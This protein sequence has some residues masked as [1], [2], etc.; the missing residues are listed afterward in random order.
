MRGNPALRVLFALLAVAL[1]ATISRADDP[2]HP[3]MTWVKRH[4][5]PDAKKPSPALGYETT[6]GYDPARDLLIRYGGHNQGGG[7]EQ[8]SE[9]WTYDLANDVWT[10][11]QPNDAPP[12]V[13]CDQ[14]NVYHDA[15]G[16]FVR[17]P[18]FSGSHGWQSFREIN[19]KD[20]SV[21]TYDLAANHWR[22]MRP[23]PEVHPGPL[24]GAA[25]DAHHEV[26]VLH[27]GEGASHGT[28]A[29]DL[30]SNTWHRLKPSGPAPEANLS[31]PGFTYD[32]VNRVFV[33]F[34]SQFAK[35][36]K[37]WLYD[38]R[39]N[40][41]SVLETPEH[42]PADKSCPVLAADTRS[43]V[44][45][46][47]VIGS[48]EL[49]TWTLDVAKAKWVK[50]ET[51]GRPDKSGGRNRVLLYIPEKN[52]FVLENRTERI[53][54][55]PQTAKRAREQQIWTFRYADAPA[56]SPRPRDLK[57]ST[58]A[59]G[60]RL[61]WQPPEGAGKVTYNVYR[62]EGEKAWEVEL[63]PVAKGV[64][65]TSFD[66]VK[67]TPA[68]TCFYQV[69]AVDGSGKEG[70]P[71]LF[72]RTQPPL[73]ADVFCSVTGPKGVELQWQKPAADDIAGYHVERAVV[74]VYSSDQVLRVAKRYR[75]ASDQAVGAI[76]QVG[77][78]ERL[79]KD[80]VAATTYTD[81]TA[82]FEGGP[83]EPAGEPLGGRVLK[84]DQLTKEG[85]PYR[86]GVYAYRVRAVNALGVLGGPSPVVFTYPSAVQHVETKEE[87]QTHTRL[88]WKPNRETGIKGYLVY[89]HD[90][91][92][93][94][95]NIVRL[96]PEPIRATEF[97]DENSGKDTRRYEVVAVDALGQEG[98]PS[99]P[100]WS[101]REWQRYY[102]P[103]VGEWHQ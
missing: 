35:D 41:W 24:R 53:E 30:Y 55:D 28:V 10:H 103:Y 17:F 93:E 21:W 19:L 26:I 2:P 58:S 48:E 63:Q 15:L 47:N 100:V 23:L 82:D 98:E 8:N 16:K 92:Y 31:Q 67:V 79:T 40:A 64:G 42:P 71:S 84:E 5:L 18:S 27:G 44:V 97:L 72:A 45:L 51:K 52:L 85:K 50:L 65:G 54:D 91:R 7:G 13:C 88:R 89:R 61:T 34:G 86:H 4:P 74:S 12:G 102:L 69:R 96:T 36:P 101:R 95:D 46:C 9:V 39:K 38:L 60:V 83:R 70:T 49:E 43:G 99:Q 80:A 73:V 59:R 94:K 77:P 66:D 87:G 62:G 25:Y 6:Y 68:T 29:Y 56:P 78:F 14:Q 76:K 33:L 37:T 90:G 75:P 11:M 22:A 57:A 81:A 3:V 20:S 1:P 32:A